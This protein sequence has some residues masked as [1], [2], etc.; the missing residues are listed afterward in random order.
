ME[1]LPITEPIATNKY[2]I[3]E[4]SEHY[5][6]VNLLISQQLGY[7]RDGTSRYAP[8]EPDTF[9]VD[10]LP[11][12]LITVQVQEQCNLEGLELVDSFEPYVDEIEIP[13]EQ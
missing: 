8:E 3:C 7:E 9:N 2:I 5:K 13:E 11:V 6:A 4:S 12:M 10:N 1:E